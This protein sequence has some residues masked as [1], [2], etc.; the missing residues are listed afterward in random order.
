VIFKKEGFALSTRRRLV[1][2]VSVLSIEQRMQRSQASYN[3]LLI[4][5]DEATSEMLIECI[6]SES[7]FRFKSL[8]SGEEALQHLQEIK[9][10]V[11]F[12]FIIDYLLPGMNGLQLFDHLQSLEIFEQV[13]VILITATT[14]NEDIQTTLRDRR[15]ALFTNPLEL[16]DLLDYLEH[17]QNSSH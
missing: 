1:T 15:V 8:S 5:D 7:S 12:L 11:P 6:E 17:F 2:A 10:A 9:E 14:M 3:I 16:A 13:P 4:E